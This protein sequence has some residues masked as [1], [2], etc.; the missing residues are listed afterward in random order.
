IYGLAMQQFLPTWLLRHVPSETIYSQIDY[1]AQQ[2]CYSAEDV[3]L[4]T[5]GPSDDF[6]PL[7]PRQQQEEHEA[8]ML[9][10]AYRSGGKVKGTV[11]QGGSATG[12]VADAEALRSSFYRT[13][14]PYLLHGRKSDRA[15]SSATKA[16]QFFENLRSYV[17]RAAW[18]AVDILAG[19]CA[20]R[21]Q[22]DLQ[23]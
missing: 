2:S 20:Q 22:F 21:R 17:D 6:E 14:A 15:L 5:C 12:T 4:T 16:D 13:I 8:F 19:L 10:G 3:V 9:I 18:P 7:R 23:R 11:L 1:V